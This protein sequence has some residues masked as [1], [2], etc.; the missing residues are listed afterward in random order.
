MW[1]HGE[2]LCM[3]RGG[4]PCQ[5]NPCASVWQRELGWRPQGAQESTVLSSLQPGPVALEKVSGHQQELGCDPQAVLSSS[6][7]S[8]PFHGKHALSTCVYMLAAVALSTFGAGLF[9]YGGRAVQRF[10][11]PHWMSDTPT[12]MTP[13]A[14]ARHATTT[15][16]PQTLAGERGR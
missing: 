14:T 16:S 6:K 8:S 5:G 9:C 1:T 11:S 3:G 10:W 13:V 7:N 2:D 4:N 12:S 15:T